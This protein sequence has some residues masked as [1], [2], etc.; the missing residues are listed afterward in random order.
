MNLAI[1]VGDV[2]LA[3][4]EDDVVVHSLGAVAD[5]EGS[6]GRGLGHFVLL[7]L[8]A[9]TEGIIL[10]TLRP[11]AFFFKKSEKKFWREATA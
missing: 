7:G 8:V 3:I 1:V 4:D 9:G 5:D 2:F 6:C 10:Q 11:L